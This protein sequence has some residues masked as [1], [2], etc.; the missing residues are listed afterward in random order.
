M[1]TFVDVKE[2]SWYYED[3]IEAANTRLKD[4]TPLID[5]IPYNVFTTSHPY[6]IKDVVATQKDQKIF[7][8][9]DDITNTGNLYV[10]ING[11]QTTTKKKEFINGNTRVELYQG[12][13]I[14]TR[15][16]FLSV[17]TPKVDPYLQRPVDI[18]DGYTYP[19]KMLDNSQYALDGDKYDLTKKYGYYYESFYKGVLE[20]CYVFGNRLGRV[21]I[22]QKLWKLTSNGKKPDDGQNELLVRKFIGLR[23]DVYTVSPWGRIY[24]PYN[25]NGARVEFSYSYIDKATGSLRRAGGGGQ[26]SATAINSRNPSGRVLHNNRVFPNAIASRGDAITLISRLREYFY[27]S[28]TDSPAPSVKFTEIQESTYVGQRIFNLNNTF[29]PNGADLTVYNAGTN[30]VIL[31]N[32]YEESPNG[33]TVIFK[34]E[35][36]KGTKIKFTT[37][38]LTDYVDVGVVA[39]F[40][41]MPA[42]EFINTDGLP[43]P[44]N[45]ATGVLDMFADKTIVRGDEKKVLDGFI[46]YTNYKISEQ[47]VLRKAA[48]DGRVG[49]RPCILFNPVIAGLPAPYTTGGEANPFAEFTPTVSKVN[50]PKPNDFKITKPTGAGAVAGEYIFTWKVDYTKATANGLPFNNDSATVYFE[51]WAKRVPYNSYDVVGDY[52]LMTRITPDFPS[53]GGTVTTTYTHF[54]NGG[55]QTD[56]LDAEFKV[57]AVSHSGSKSDFSDEL[58][59]VYDDKGNPTVII[60]A[61]IDQ[62]APTPTFITLSQSVDNYTD[63]GNGTTTVFRNKISWN[64]NANSDYYIIYLNNEPHVTIPSPLGAPTMS[65]RFPLVCKGK[66]T[67]KGYDNKGF[68]RAESRVE[69]NITGSTVT[70]VKSIE[71]TPIPTLETI[72]LS[73]KLYIDVSGQTNPVEVSIEK[74]YSKGFELKSSSPNPTSQW[75]TAWTKSL[76]LSLIDT[77]FKIPGIGNYYRF[78]SYQGTDIIWRVIEVLDDGNIMLMSDRVLTFKAFSAAGKKFSSA[79][80]ASFGSNYWIHST[81][82]EWLNSSSLTVNYS[83]NKPTKDNVANGTNAYDTEKGFLNN[84]TSDE[85]VILTPYERNVVVSSANVGLPYQTLNDQTHKFNASLSQVLQNYNTSYQ[86]TVSDRVFLPSVSILKEYVYDNSAT[87]GSTYYKA[88]PTGIAVQQSSFNNGKFNVD[89]FCE[90][91]LETPNGTTEHLVRY[92][93][94]YGIPQVDNYLVPIPETP[95]PTGRPKYFFA[96]TPLYRGE[97]VRVMNWFRLW[98]IDRF[99]NYT[100]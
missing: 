100:K 41:Q 4:G 56:W 29:V 75:T 30:T 27:D 43:R 3:F 2:D 37:E 63:P 1:I 87:L 22:P 76:N 96:D 21:S 68:L 47:T 61:A 85:R 32:N 65:F 25:A 40:I 94:D 28:L 20:S 51:I 64:T 23:H 81:L 97:F 24:L 33:H 86:T 58:A 77:S 11:I 14:G 99:Q 18:V 13:S 7:E 69:Y 79:Q 71:V 34:N 12:Q 83:Y 26:F 10:Y 89:S 70:P 44:Y 38:N 15:V 88:K 8:I 16:T 42:G 31:P 66:V 95:P 50:L 52:E 92:V 60:P 39:D 82:R 19:Q 73:D 90:Y 74:V 55:S 59:D 9:S 48:Y 45:W 84:F 46:S 91:W 57:R 98:C 5:A 67:V 49:V 6:V 72:D 17:G 35:V 80:R 93:N 36:P 78:G 53:G 62:V 54:F